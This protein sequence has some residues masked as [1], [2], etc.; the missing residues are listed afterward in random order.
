MEENEM[1]REQIL[2]EFKVDEHGIIRD[3]GKFEGEMLYAPYFDEIAMDG[4]VEDVYADL[5]DDLGEEDKELCWD[6]AELL[7]TEVLVTDED[8]TK[9]PELDP[10][11]K[12]V[13]VFES[14]QGFAHVE[15]V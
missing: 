5:A 2:K 12:A 10:A 15:E 4:D 11:T 8:R 6:D 13:R 14:D 1:I 7:Y 3:P 9:F